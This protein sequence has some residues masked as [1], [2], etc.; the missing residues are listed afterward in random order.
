MFRSAYL[1]TVCGVIR[2][3]FFGLGDAWEVRWEVRLSLARQAV[4]A[5][6]I[7]AL[8]QIVLRHR[9]GE[10]RELVLREEVREVLD[11]IVGQLMGE[12]LVQ[13]IKEVADLLG[14]R[15]LPRE[16]KLLRTYITTQCE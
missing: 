14:L 15:V 5:I 4:R 1:A 10:V 9:T 8:L 3:G 2:N 7:S 11:R 13:A 6:P 12:F 16:R